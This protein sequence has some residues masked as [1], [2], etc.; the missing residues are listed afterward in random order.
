[1]Q[2]P[3]TDPQDLPNVT[4]LQD[5]LEQELLRGPAR[6]EV[7]ERLES[8]LAA[9]G[10][11]SARLA[12]ELVFHHYKTRA[13]DKAVGVGASLRSS[14]ARFNG[15]MGVCLQK[16]G[17]DARAVR[18]L[19]M[20]ICAAPSSPD[21]YANVAT[22]Y[23]IKTNASVL[24]WILCFPRVMQRAVDVFSQHDFKV[25]YE[26]MTSSS[27]IT[28][29]YLRRAGKTSNFPDLRHSGFQL[30][31]D[32]L[33]M[34][35]IQ[36]T[37]AS[38]RAGLASLGMPTDKTVLESVRRLLV[39]DPAQP[40]LYRSK[41]WLSTW[42]PDIDGA[43]IAEQTR[44]FIIRRSLNSVLKPASRQIHDLEGIRFVIAREL[45]Q[46]EPTHRTRLYRIAK[47]VI[48]LDQCRWHHPKNPSLPH[49]TRPRSQRIGIYLG[50]PDSLTAKL[51]MSGLIDAGFRRGLRL[52]LYFNTGEAELA[53]TPL[54]HVVQETRTDYSTIGHLDD[55]Q[56]AEQI[57]RDDLAVFIDARGLSRDSRLRIIA[58][59]PA[60]VALS[61]IGTAECTGFDFLD[62]QL[63]D[64]SLF[65]P[66]CPDGIE[67]PPPVLLEGGLLNYHPP[68]DFPALPGPRADGAIR[69]AALHHPL[70]INRP[71]IEY[72]LSVMAEIDDSTL[73]IRVPDDHG[74]ESV[75]PMVRQI[76][77]QKG[78]ATDR[79]LW[80]PRKKTVREHLDV[81]ASH[82]IALDSFPFNGET[83]TLECLWLG[84]PLISR[85]DRRLVS[86][87]GKSI[88][89][90]SGLGHLAGD[91]IADCVRIAVDL[92]GDDA[93]R[94]QFRAAARSVLGYQPTFNGKLYADSVERALLDLLD[95]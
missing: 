29:S 12:S 51:L 55:V 7:I 94:A 42:A 64:R 25:F 27:E 1:M 33:L 15:V 46:V 50:D 20:A 32:Q 90:H 77:L 21:V 60:P 82:D 86:R 88:L 91:T 6:P 24:R 54:G 92:A 31:L 34:H 89:D 74:A 59:R 58:S 44:E 13:F 93:W 87:F 17:H 39:W 79:I 23:P 53:A 40:Y 78:I 36:N 22:F 19:R 48:G 41:S 76:A 8:D 75:Q 83:T 62:G 52:K 28:A 5:A 85:A 16:T 84:I 11:L 61:M 3:P 67:S 63:L 69:L 45:N 38:F 73:S 14:S 49:R 9:S 30:V 43:R 81:L 2:T 95:P 35:L 47:E 68:V 66:A 10:H 18:S 26:S 70:K 37:D 72:W 57:A 4:Q 80:A 71:S 56:A 65:D